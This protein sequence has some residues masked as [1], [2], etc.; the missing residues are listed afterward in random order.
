EGLPED[1]QAELDQ[2]RR[3]LNTANAPEPFETE[4]ISGTELWTQ[5][6][7]QGSVV[8]VGLAAKDVSDYIHDRAHLLEDAPFIADMSSGCLYALSH[9]ETS[10]EIARWLH[11]LRRPALKRD[12]YAVV[13]SMPETMDN[14]WVVDRWGFTPQAL[15]VMQRLKL[16][17]DP[18]GVLNA[19]VFL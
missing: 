6:L 1:V 8:R 3:V 19:G 10:I 7:S 14:A 18:N 9:G 11:A 2:V 4:Q 16:R 12:G 13:M 17:W 15:D 5:T